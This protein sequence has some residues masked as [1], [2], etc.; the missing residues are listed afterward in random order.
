MNPPSRRSSHP[1]ASVFTDRW[2]PRAFS[3]TPIDEATLNSFF[4]A[5]RWAPSAN[6]GQP[7]RFVFGRQ[8]TPAFAPILD[9]LVPFNQTWAQHAAALVVVISAREGVAPGKTEARPIPTHSFDTGAAWA[10]LALQ[11]QL[12]G[13]HAHAMGGFDNPKL[14]ASLGVPASHAIE[15]VVA[16]GQ[17]GDPATLPEA[18]QAREFPNDRRPLAELVAEGRFSFKD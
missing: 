7:W 8:G 18:L 12:S 2:S 15:C 6:N 17:K 1:V 3:A 13:W 4:E 9:A 14:A 10:S 5:A 11:A 16:I